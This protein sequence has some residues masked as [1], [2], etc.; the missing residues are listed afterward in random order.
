[1]FFLTQ[2]GERYSTCNC[3][4]GDGSVKLSSTIIILYYSCARVG[5]QFLLGTVNQ[6]D[7]MNM[8]TWGSAM[9]VVLH[10]SKSAIAPQQILPLHD[11][12]RVYIRR[13]VF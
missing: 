9:E 8:K 11:Q 6:D 2:N 5:L 12:S 7:I 3:M 1:M 4:C 13:T 10:A